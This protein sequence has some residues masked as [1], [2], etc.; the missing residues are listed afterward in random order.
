M[1]DEKTREKT[2]IVVVT[3]VYFILASFSII[4]KCRTACSIW[5]TVQ[6]VKMLHLYNLCI[7]PIPI[8]AY[9]QL[10]ILNSQRV[11]PNITDNTTESTCPKP[12]KPKGFL[13][14]VFHIPQKKGNK[15]NRMITKHE[16]QGVL[17]DF[18]NAQNNY[19]K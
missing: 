6:N 17:L 15:E 12:A 13:K 4:W 16:H 1:Q 2:E 3:H 11:E 8:V 10:F 18:E 5:Q 7:K 9:G 14:N 19:I